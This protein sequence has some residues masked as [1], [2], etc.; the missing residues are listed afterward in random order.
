MAAAER[1]P[2]KVFGHD[3][4]LRGVPKYYV[5]IREHNDAWIACR[6]LGQAQNSNRR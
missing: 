3:P 2:H 6:L 5:H 1:S 4:F